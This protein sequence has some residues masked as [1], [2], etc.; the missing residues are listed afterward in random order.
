M[1]HSIL[2]TEEIL[3]TKA[4]YADSRGL[5]P[6]LILKLIT[7]S[8]KNP[9]ELR[10][11]F[12]G[13]IGQSGWDGRVVS[14]YAYHPYVPEGQSFWES[15]ASDKPADMANT[16][17]NK[18]TEQTSEAE[19]ESS[20]FVFVTP[21]SASHGWTADAQNK[22]LKKRREKTNW[23]DIRIHDATKLVQ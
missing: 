14:P 5:L 12:G 2:I 10:I 6:E 23:K 1:Q 20:T 11:P 15:S 16:N 8:I 22:W 18:R 9:D 7:A 4:D 17:F 13:S 3:N 21:R 19:R